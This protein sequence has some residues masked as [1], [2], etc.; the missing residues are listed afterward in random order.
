MHLLKTIEN[1]SQ[2]MELLA[3]M[4]K[5]TDVAELLQV[6]KGPESYWARRSAH[7]KTL[8]WRRRDLIS[9]EYAAV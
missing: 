8:P 9:R 6:A 4:T 1:S 3:E 2:E 5:L 7:E